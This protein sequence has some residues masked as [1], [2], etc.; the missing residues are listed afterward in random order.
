MSLQTG[1]SV[2][3]AIYAFSNG[4]YKTTIDKLMPIKNTTA[5]FGGSHAQRDVVART[6]LEASIR[7]GNKSL[8][9]A[10]INERLMA[11]PNSPYNQKKLDQ[12]IT[13]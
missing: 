9:L 4:D 12:I 3:E 10:L 8:A 5:Q 11:R 1:L 7:V 6:L 2:C 13:I